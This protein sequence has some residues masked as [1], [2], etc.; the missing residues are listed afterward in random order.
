[1]N[2]NGTNNIQASDTNFEVGDIVDWMGSLGV[3]K[4][5]EHSGDYPIECSFMYGIGLLH[6][7]FFTAKGRALYWH[8]GVSL[9]LIHKAKKKITVECWVNVLKY[10]TTICYN[11]KKD[12]EFAAQIANEGVLTV[13]LSKEIEI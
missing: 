4:C 11:T 10:G 9:K 13:H 7:H 1:M 3:V 2:T 5:T 12:A 8:K 6:T